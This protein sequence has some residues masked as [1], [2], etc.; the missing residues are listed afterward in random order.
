[1]VT[2]LFNENK[3]AAIFQNQLV[4]W[5]REMFG[6][7]SLVTNHRNVNKLTTIEAREKMKTVLESLEFDNFFVVFTKSKNNQN[8]KD[9]RADTD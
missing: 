1:M 6:F 8:L 4:A 9:L 3:S 5:V 2:V 7:F